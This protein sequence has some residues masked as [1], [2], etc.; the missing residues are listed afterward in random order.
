[1][2]KLMDQYL[3]ESVLDSL[4]KKRGVIVFGR[5]NP[6]T[7]GHGKLIERVIEVADGDDHFIFPSPTVDKPSKQLGRVD[8]EKSRN[9]LP[10]EAKVGIMRELFPDANIVQDPEIVSLFHAMGYMRDNGY[11]DVVL[12]AGEDRVPAYKDRLEQPMSESFCS[13]EIVSAGFRDPDGDGTVGMSAT[14]ARTAALK[15]DLGMFRAATG[16]KGIIA[17]QLLRAVRGSMGLL[18]DDD[19]HI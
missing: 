10:W 9:P 8:P 3:E 4:P 16:W 1:M 18:E 7:M 19:Q 15:D 11:T 2:I 17:E 14:K 5:F 13:F 12:V 6:P